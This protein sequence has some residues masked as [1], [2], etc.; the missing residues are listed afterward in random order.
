M[1]LWNWWRDRARRESELEEEIQTHLRLATRD[2]IER[3][4]KMA[5]APF[6][7]RREFGNV[8]LVREVTR[9]QWAWEWLDHLGRDARYAM[10]SLWRNP[11]FSA[12]TALSLAL[13]IGSNT[14]LARRA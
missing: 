12:V 11:V 5:E 6:Q 1:T 2:L 9:A 10:R 7:A 14:A 13:S 3:G 4:E 8:M